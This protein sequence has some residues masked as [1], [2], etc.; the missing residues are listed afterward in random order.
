MQ[1]TSDRV[2]KFDESEIASAVGADSDESAEIL[3]IAGT[4]F[5]PIEKKTSIEKRQ[6][7]PTFAV[8]SRTTPESTM[9]SEANFDPTSVPK[10]LNSNRKARRSVP[11]VSNDAIIMNTRSR[12]QAYATALKKMTDFSSYYSA[13][14][15]KLIRPDFEPKIRLHRDSLLIESKH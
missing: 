10:A 9:I 11:K 15:V 8:T 2:T 6:L 1:L 5:E 3:S 12:R 14:A 13:F 7:M 4:A